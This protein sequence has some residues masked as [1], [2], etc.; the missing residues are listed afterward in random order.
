MKSESKKLP[1]ET[2]ERLSIHGVTVAP[3]F[4]PKIIKT[5]CVSVISPELMKPTTITV[6]SE[7]DCI[8]AVTPVPRA[9]P[10]MGFPVTFFRRSLS[11]WPARFSNAPPIR[12]IPK[13]KRARPPISVSPS[14]ISIFVPAPYRG[15]TTIGRPL[16]PSPAFY[17]FFIR[18]KCIISVIW[19]SSHKTAFRSH[20]SRLP[21]LH[22]SCPAV[23]LSFRLYI[24]R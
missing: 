14:K 1:P 5:D 19:L 22:S 20:R 6:V 10:T 15:K 11:L 16:G 7:D 23:R 17:D 9:R 2:P 4:A 18:S 12:F 8:S 3:R 24:S 13:R 21:A